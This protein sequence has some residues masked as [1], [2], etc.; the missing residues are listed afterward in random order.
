[1]YAPHGNPWPSLAATSVS[2]G[3]LFHGKAGV[4]HYGPNWLSVVGQG[5]LFITHLG[6]IIY[7][8]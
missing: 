8:H 1:M 7:V 3:Y 6:S 2:E 5:Y 4:T